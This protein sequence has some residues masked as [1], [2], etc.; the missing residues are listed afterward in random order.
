[1][2]VYVNS[3]KAYAAA[4]LLKTV[5]GDMLC[6]QKAVNTVLSYA[7]TEQAFSAERAFRTVVE[8]HNTVGL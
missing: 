4:V 2:L 8:F 5:F 1:M 3:Q 7:D 6:P